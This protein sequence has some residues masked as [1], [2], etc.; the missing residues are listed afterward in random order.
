MEVTAEDSTIK[1]YTITVTRAAAISND[2]DLGALA[3]SPGTL[4]PTFS[5]STITYT[6][7]V[8]NSVTQV[9]VTPTASDGSAMITVNGDPVTSGSGHLVTGLIVG[10]NTVTVE[11]T[12]EDST[13]KTYTITVTRAAAI[14]N[15]A[16]L[17]ALA[18]SPGTLSPTFSASTITYTT[19]VANSVTQVTV[20][21]TASD[22]SA[23]ITVNGDPVT[24]G[25]GHLVTGLIVGANTVTVEVTAEDSTI[26]TYTITVTRA[27]AISNDADLGAL[28]ISP[29]TLSPTFSDS[30]TA[31]TTNVANSVTQVTVT[32][33]ASD[34]SAMITVNGDPVTSGSG[35]LVTGLNVGAN[36][37]HGGGHRPGL[38]HQDLHHYR[39]ARCRHLQRRRPRRPGN[40]PRHPEP[41]VF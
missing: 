14:S 24:S 29:G 26:K 22:G 31:Y 13:I 33:T 21:P 10:A 7:N 12:A 38:Y 15:D 11:V 16:D 35:H 32:P 19:N 20:T 23:M 18:I 3:I 30:T 4:S 1:T 5:A 34:G 25:S 2:A 28:A 6:T 37:V 41:D 8:A 39:Y 27:A 40:Q 17:G 36:T 9:T